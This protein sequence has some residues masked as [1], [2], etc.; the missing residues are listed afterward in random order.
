MKISIE[1]NDDLMTKAKKL[2][3]IENETILIEKALQ[4]FIAIEN[5]KQITNLIGKIEFDEEAFK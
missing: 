1:I 5:Q 4:L 2:S 3:G